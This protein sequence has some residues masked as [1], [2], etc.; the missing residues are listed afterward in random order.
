MSCITKILT[1]WIVFFVLVVPFP[2]FGQIKPAETTISLEKKGELTP[3]LFF[4]AD[5]FVID[6]RPEVQFKVSKVINGNTMLLDNGEVVR[7]IG[8]E[9]P[10]EFGVEA[11][12]LLRGLLEGKEVKL[13]FER[14]N[15]NIEGQRLAYV[16]KDG[17]SVNNL[18]RERT[19]Y[20]NRVDPSLSYV[21]VFLEGIFS[22]RGVPMDSWE[23]VLGRP[24]PVVMKAKVVLKTGETLRGA[25][26]SETPD[27]IILD[28]KFYGK[29]VVEKKK[30]AQLG[31]E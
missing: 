29:E 10:E 4:D 2:I 8:V 5:S 1:G 19:S 18:L 14:R 12:R 21:P 9:I 31:F 30:I 6:R 24:K 11:H 25:L 20:Y 3:P 23:I 13:E 22:E 15:R 27:Y 7:L 17:V 16:F 26:V 28:R